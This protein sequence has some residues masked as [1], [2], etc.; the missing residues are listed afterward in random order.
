MPGIRQ[1]DASFGG[2]RKDSRSGPLGTYHWP[3]T[4]GNPSISIGAY[5]N[6]LSVYELQEDLLKMT[7]EDALGRKLQDLQ[8]LS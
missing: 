5:V 2:Q 7:A 1:G 3:D 4:A 6:V 8:L